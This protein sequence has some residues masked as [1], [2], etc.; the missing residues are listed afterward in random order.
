MALRREGADDALRDMLALVRGAL[1][2]DDAA[3]EVVAANMSWPELTAGFLAEWVAEML[4]MRGLGREAIDEWQ[5][6]KGLR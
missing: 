4:R 6:S 5:T 1:D 2:D 3:I